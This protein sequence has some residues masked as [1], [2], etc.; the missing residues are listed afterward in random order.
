[1]EGPHQVVLKVRSCFTGLR[2]LVLLKSSPKNRRGVF[3][4]RET[5]MEIFPMQFFTCHVLDVSSSFKL[6]QYVVNQTQMIFLDKVPM[7]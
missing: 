1:M 2:L 7:V 3:S 6:V 5:L 4:P